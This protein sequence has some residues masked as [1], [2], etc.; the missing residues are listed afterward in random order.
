MEEKIS[1]D[2]L[3]VCLSVREADVRVG[4]KHTSAYCKHSQ[5]CLL[6]A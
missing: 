5:L 6:L 2:R 4:G 3:S 1:Y